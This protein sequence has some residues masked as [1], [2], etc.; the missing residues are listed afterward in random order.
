MTSCLHWACAVQMKDRRLA[1]VTK[2]KEEADK[3]LDAS[4]VRYGQLRTQEACEAE[5]PTGG[6]TRG[7]LKRNDMTADTKIRIF[8]DDGDVL[9][10]HQQSCARRYG[11]EPPTIAR[12]RD[13]V[14]ES[15]CIQRDD[16]TYTLLD[17]KA[18]IIV[19]TF[20]A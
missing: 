18:D 5:R 9:S 11:F 3:L 2:Q 14:A 7:R 17:N 6:K 13:Q 10:G 20:A 4:S 19:P 15:V 12:A 8:F 1:K 16:A